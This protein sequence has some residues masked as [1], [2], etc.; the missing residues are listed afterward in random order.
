MRVMMQSFEV[1]MYTKNAIAKTITVVALF[2]ATWMFAAAGVSSGPI[3]TPPPPVPFCQGDCPWQ[4]DIA[5]EKAD[6]Q[7]PFCHEINVNYWDHDTGHCSKYLCSNGF[8]YTFSGWGFAG[9][10]VDPIAPTNPICP[11]GTCAPL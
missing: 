10:V 7:G 11:A 6:V 9:C 4:F 3:G 2:S 5:K 8:Y 1:P